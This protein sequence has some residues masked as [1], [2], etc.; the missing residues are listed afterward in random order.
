MLNPQIAST[1]RRGLTLVEV[2][3]TIAIIA[4]IVALSLAAISRLRRSGLIAQNV[5]NLRNLAIADISYFTD[6]RVFPDLGTI[7]PSSI[8]VER[9]RQ[10]GNYL[11]LDVPG[12]TAIEWPV[13]AQQP[14]WINSPFAVESDYALGLTVGGGLYTGYVY[15]AGIEDSQMVT[16]GIATIVNPGHSAHRRNESRGVMWADVLGEFNTN[17]ERRFET[18]RVKP[19]TPRYSDFRFYRKE[20]EGIHRAWSDGSV[21]WLDGANID[22][23]GAGSRDLRIQHM[24]GNFYY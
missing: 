21:D 15:V 14:V 11:G 23:S 20:F 22:L 2:L 10:I 9:L 18:F 6:H 4:L 1:T 12:G 19:G 24:L 8:R 17:E 5:N 16:S 3:V 7:V 13:R